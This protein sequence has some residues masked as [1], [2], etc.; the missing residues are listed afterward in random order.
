[1]V[2]VLPMML[3]TLKLAV[4]AV[5]SAAKSSVIV[6]ELEPVAFVAVRVTA[7]IP[8]VAYVC[9]VVVAVEVRPSM[10]HKRLV[11]FADWLMNVTDSPD[12]LY[13]NLAATV[14][15]GFGNIPIKFANCVLV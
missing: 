14:G 4:G 15:D 10:F 8:P 7:F 12:T 1:M 11:A 9:V 13:E 6:F 5:L 2:T 3:S